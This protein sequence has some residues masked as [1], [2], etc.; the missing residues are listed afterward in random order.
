MAEFITIEPANEH[1]SAFARWALDQDPNVQTVGTHGFVVPLDWYPEIPTELLKGSYVDGFS[2]DRSAP[3][4]AKLVELRLPVPPKD[5]PKPEPA[6][7]PKPEPAAEPKPEPKPE[8]R[9]RAPRKPK[10]ADAP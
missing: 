2:Y 8:P 3:Q 7:E 4:P 10:A 9:K 5:E 1:R 6:A